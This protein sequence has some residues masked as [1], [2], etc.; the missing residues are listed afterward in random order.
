VRYTGDRTHSRKTSRKSPGPTSCERIPEPPRRPRGAGENCDPPAIV[1]AS[2]KTCTRLSTTTN[3]TSYSDPVATILLDSPTTRHTPPERHTHLH[4]PIHVQ[5]IRQHGLGRQTHTHAG[6][7][8]A[9]IRTGTTKVRIQRSFQNP[10]QTIPT[11]QPN[12]QANTH[13]QG[14]TTTPAKHHVPTT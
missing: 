2:N 12:T 10:T 11:V 7:S 8:R 4:L 9:R 5:A 1:V 3:I 6:A 14:L 13:G